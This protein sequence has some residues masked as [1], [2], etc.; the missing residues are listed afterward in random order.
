MMVDIGEP[1]EEVWHS[2]CDVDEALLVV[3]WCE[4][5]SIYY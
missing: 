2:L 1:V 4:G 5:V 3:Y